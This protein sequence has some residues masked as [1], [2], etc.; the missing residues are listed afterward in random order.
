[1]VEPEIAPIVASPAPYGYRNRMTFHA[2]NG[3]PGLY[4]RRSK[5][6]A[7]IS[8]C[9]L[10]EP[11]LSDL[12]GQLGDLA[13]VHEIT[14]RMGATTGE[15]AVLIR[16]RVPEHA[17]RW[18]ASVV[19]LAGRRFEPVIGPPHIHEEVGGMVFRITG[20]AFFQV[21][22]AGAETLTE[23]VGDAL[24]PTGSDTLLDAYAGVGLFAATVGTASGRVIAVES[25][26]VALTDLRHNLAE[27]GVP[28]HEIIRG[29]FEEVDL[30]SRWT[31]AVCDPP[32]TGLAEAGVS[33]L[34]AG[35]P[36]R[37]AYVSCDPASLA[38]DTRLL[39]GAGYRLVE[40]TPVDLFPQT[41]HIETVAKFELK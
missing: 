1:M 9:L 23:L 21:N 6:L 31:L 41:F 37:I 16:G 12:Y 29:R 33:A 4:R 10:L 36:R 22:T 34:V 40:A 18:K 19:R 24:Q 14:I 30:A 2:E 7:P 11:G 5:E 17:P 39:A 15:R 20:P 25:S 3:R 27:A 38:R 28:N 8:A 35:G 32:R 26:G 13:G